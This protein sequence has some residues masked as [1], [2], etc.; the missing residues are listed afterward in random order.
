MKF[1][2]TALLSALAASTFSACV[3]IVVGTAAVV[4][5]VV[6]TDR[7]T[8]GMQLTDKT[9]DITVGNEAK[10]VVNPDTSRI[11][12]SAF[13]QRAL[14]TGEVATAE[15]K[16]RV[17]EAAKLSKDVKYIVNELVV[18]PKSSFK[19]RTNDS[20]ITSKVRSELTLSENVPSRPIAITTSQGVVYLMGE[21]TPEEADKAANAA[22]RIRGV[23]RVVKVFDI[24]DPTNKTTSPAYNHIQN[25]SYSGPMIQSPATG[26][27]Q[28]APSKPPSNG[29]QTFPVN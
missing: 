9:I 18:G 13:N 27:A 26:V 20:W 8:T 3:P 11:N 10:K 14:I 19:S 25:S 21:V 6:A 7:R 1:Y 4:T 23:K 29:V 2:K 15:E 16:A 5:A 28:P 22:S 12:V 24:I 17:T